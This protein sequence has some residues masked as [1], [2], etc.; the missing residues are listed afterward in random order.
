[1]VCFFLF[2]KILFHLRSPLYF[3]ASLHLARAISRR[4]ERETV[5][6]AAHEAVPEGVVA[7]LNRLSSWLFVAARWVNLQQG[8]PET[9][10]KGLPRK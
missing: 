2:F 8:H 7:Y 4:A 6:L 5:G 1:M 3:G 10:W 9:P